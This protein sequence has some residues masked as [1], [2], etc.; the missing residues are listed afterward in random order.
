MIIDKRITAHTGRYDSES[1]DV[2][3]TFQVI[4]DEWKD[5]P[6]AIAIQ[7]TTE[8]DNVTDDTGK[9]NGWLGRGKPYRFGHE[10]DKRII[11]SEVEVSD[12]KPLDADNE[13][14]LKISKNQIG[15]ERDEHRI[16]LV[17]WTVKQNFKKPSFE[18][19]EPKEDD[20]SGEDD[21]FTLK[22]GKEWIDVPFVRDVRTGKLILN[23]AGDPFIPTP[24]MKKAVR[25]YTLTRKER[26]NN[27]KLYEKYENVVNEDEWY[28]ARPGTVLMEAITPSWDG[29]IFTVDY[30]FKYNSDGWGEKYLDTGLRRLETEVITIP[31]TDTWT[32]EKI[33]NTKHF[34]INAPGSQTPVEEP[35]KLDG[36]GQLPIHRVEK[37]YPFLDTEGNPAKDPD[38]NEELWYETG[39]PDYVTDSGDKKYE[40][41][42]N[43]Y[44]GVDLPFDP[45]SRKNPETEKWEK[46]PIEEQHY[47]WKYKE[48]PFSVLKI[49]NPYSVEPKPQP[50]FPET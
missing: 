45:P 23:S 11:A 34:P 7:G 39:E 9:V 12:R 10:L 24:A 43:N 2:S 47:F 8:S 6:L 30:S 46:I 49:P 17:Q 13:F 50:K 1:A 48:L 36:K 14:S 20:N 38:T 4:T 40:K 27:L 26:V 15:L 25:T 16:A 18:N 3:I 31:H 35:V 44:P 19:Q 41:Q 29:N 33:T 22:Y 32:I 28:G 37:E 42:Y 5:G 21:L